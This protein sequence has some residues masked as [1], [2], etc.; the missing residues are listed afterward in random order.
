MEQVNKIKPTITMEQIYGKIYMEQIYGTTFSYRWRK[1]T[2]R[3]ASDG[4]ARHSTIC[5]F[6]QNSALR[7]EQAC[8]CGRESES[9]KAIFDRPGATVLSS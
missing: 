6:P 4:G 8:V 9:E 3:D 2:V 7:R 5:V 1:G